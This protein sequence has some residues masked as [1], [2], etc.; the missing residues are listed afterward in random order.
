[1]PVITGIDVGGTFT[2]CFMEVDGE[3][4]VI[5]VPTTYYD[6]SVCF[7]KALEEGAEKFG[8]SV[9]ELLEETGSIRYST[10]IGTNSIIERTGPKLGLITTA[11]FEDT[12]YIGRA[13]QWADGGAITENKDL[14]RIQKP[15]PLIAREMVVGVKER[16][17]CFGQVAMPL[18]REDVRQKLQYLVDG[19]AMGFAVCL[20]WSFRNPAHEQMIREIIEEEYP[21]NY[22]GNMPVLLSSEVSPMA[23]EYGRFMTT[24][25]NAYMH[26]DLSEQLAGLEEQLREKGFKKPLT[27]VHNTG[28]MKKVSRTKAVYTHNAGPVAG[29]F[30]SRYVGKLYEKE[31]IIFTDMGGTSF[32]MGIVAGGA[33]RSHDFIPVID[34]W[35]TQIPAV[36]TR[37]IGAGGGSIAWLNTIMGNLL[38]VGPQSAGA[39]PGPAAY[40]MGG[41]EP[42]VTDADIVLGYLNPRFYLGGK[43]RLNKDKALAAIREKIAGPLGIDEVEAAFRIKKII[44]ARMGQEIY[45]EVALRGHDPREF[46]LFVSGGAGAT[47]CCGFNAYLDAPKIITCPYSPVFGAFGSTT[48]DVLHIFEKSSHLKLFTF[49]GQQYLQE[50]DS[51]NRVVAELEEAAVRDLKLEGF[52]PEQV[53]FILELEMKYGSQM[54]ATKITSPVTRVRSEEDV[55]AICDAFA[56]AYVELYTPE[57]AYPE[58]GIEADT[59]FLRAWAPQPHFAFTG[60]PLAGA[61]PGSRAVKETRPV[62]WEEYMLFHPTVVYDYGELACGNVIEGPAIIEAEDTTYCIAPGY[63]FMLDQYRN[64]ILEQIRKGGD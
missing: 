58:G 63:R 5:K 43:M 22:L 27:L 38:E 56:R 45:K 47:H 18:D 16:I 2:D 44:D 12:I 52:V 40:N 57:A 29:V 51:F 35:R 14:A 34:R 4:S 10:T 61:I 42:T 31:N 54:H 11:G 36:E 21:E 3:T 24:I 33:I 25:V 15:V 20:L 64:G 60:Q 37:S 7:F 9:E 17:D 6:F 41:T 53:Q 39:M 48:L 8:V 55:R 50:Y 59:F 49:G 46:V 30:G 32:D 1:M 62:F 13:R 23:G 28:G 19:G 26:K